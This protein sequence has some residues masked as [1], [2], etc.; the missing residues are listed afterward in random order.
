MN[1]D[2]IKELE[3]KETALTVQMIEGARTGT[4][5]PTLHREL[6]EIR[7]KLKTAR[8]VRAMDAK[9]TGPKLTRKISFLMPEDEYEAVLRKADGKELS[10]YIRDIL[11]KDM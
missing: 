6:A 3:Q 7:A 11:K 1:H 5:S 9:R 10:K 4:V 8:R 2:T